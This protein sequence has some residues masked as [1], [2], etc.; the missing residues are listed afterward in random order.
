M[1]LLVD[2]DTESG[3]R[4]WLRAVRRRACISDVAF[5]LT[6]GYSEPLA[7]RLDAIS[8]GVTFFEER[9]CASQTLPAIPSCGSST[10]HVQVS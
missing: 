7:K 4:R 6:N 5:G 10:S 9:A 1:H 2:R 3:L 8:I